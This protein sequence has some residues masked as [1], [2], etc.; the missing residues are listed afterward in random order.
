MELYDLLFNDLIS[1]L[2]RKNVLTICQ[3]SG[4]YQLDNR[5]DYI[6]W[7]LTELISCE[8]HPEYLF[9][10]PEACPTYYVH[11]TT[12]QVKHHIYQQFVEFIN[13]EAEYLNT[14][15]FNFLSQSYKRMIK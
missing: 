5:I 10:K 12:G 14:T 4:R 1:F 2:K 6:R 7:Y 3:Q 11:Y 8:V 9:K 13:E 15:K